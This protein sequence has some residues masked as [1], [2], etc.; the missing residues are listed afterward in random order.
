M[1]TEPDCPLSHPESSRWQPGSRK[2]GF[3]IKARRTLGATKYLHTYKPREKS[4]YTG[5]EDFVRANLQVQQ[6]VVVSE[7]LDAGLFLGSVR[8]LP[9]SSLV[10]WQRHSHEKTPGNQ[11]TPL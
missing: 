4:S 3:I 10:A 6:H 5:D 9:A 1:F 2:C 8:R 7:E 11:C